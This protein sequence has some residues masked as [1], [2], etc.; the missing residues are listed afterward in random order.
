DAEL[1]KRRLEI[2]S[3]GQRRQ[4][5]LEGGEQQ[6][7]M[8]FDR[9]ALSQI[10]GGALEARQLANRAAGTLLEMDDWPRNQMAR[11]KAMFGTNSRLAV[12]GLILE[13]LAAGQMTRKLDES[14]AHQ[15]PENA[16]K[17]S[18]SVGAIFAGIGNLIHDGIVNGAK[19]GSVRLGRIANRWWVKYLG[20]GSRVL[21]FAAAG[22]MAVWDGVNV[23]QEI[24]KGNWGMAGLYIFAAG[25]GLGAALLLGGFFGTTITV[26]GAVL[27]A[28]GVGLLLL[29]IGIGVV[30]L[31][32]FFK[33]DAL[34]EWMGRCFF[35]KEGD[36]RYGGLKV[37]VEQFGIAMTALGIETEGEE[38]NNRSV[39]LSPQVR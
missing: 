12:I 17:L 29:A 6:V 28:S 33:N 1:L 37:E 7:Q 20:I 4:V 18:A 2:R 26:F 10:D 25:T 35:G 36:E 34:Q 9:F 23:Y 11:F 5:R 31:I 30:L 21:G 24:R 38:N 8:R 22:L 3:R 14:M 15:R 16:W 32:D 13:G 39:G 19:A 27:S